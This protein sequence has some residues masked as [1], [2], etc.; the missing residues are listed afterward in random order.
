MH[1]APPPVTRATGPPAQESLIQVHGHTNGLKASQVKA[2]E[3]LLRRR[4]SAD[5]LVTNELARELTALSSEIRRQVGVL[6]DRAGAV[7]HA[8]VGSPSETELP[9][10]GRLRAGRGRLRGL[11][12][13]KTHLADEGLTRDDLTDLAL[14]RLD[15]VVSIAVRDDG[16]PGLAHAASLCAANPDGRTTAKL[17]PCHPADLDAPFSAFIRDLENELARTTATHDVGDGERAILVSVTAGRDRATLEMHVAELRELARAAGVTVVD[18]ITQ[19]RPAVDPRTVLGAGKLS[20]LAIRCFQSDVDLVIF[21]QDMTPAQA[22]NLAERMELRVIDRTQLILDIFAQRASTGDG[23]LQVELAQLRYRMPRLSQR[24]DLSLSRLAAGIGGRGPGETKL[25]SDRRR[26]RD[27][28]TRLE[29]ETARLADQREGRRRKRGRRSVPVL[30]IVGYTN[31]GKSTLLRALTQ[32]DVHVED[33]MFAT[34]DPVSRRLRFPREREVI[35]TDTVGFIR[36]LPADLAAAFHA[37]LEELRDANL[38]LHVVD[39]AS[40]DIDRR[41]QAVRQVLGELGFD[42]KPEL[43][44]FNQIDRMPADQVDGLARRYGAVA[45]SALQS[46]GLV[47]LLERAEAMLWDDEGGIGVAARMSEPRVAQAGR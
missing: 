4:L 24:A 23:K 30:S 5:R 10:W 36:D 44:V 28:I 2:L 33:K 7:Q 18:V 29:R 31:A 22:R 11:R 45:V 19:S 37:T 1:P 14:L 40:P 38:L 9:D 20:D 34:L 39:A 13:I 8:M 26:V 35:I 46:R 27:R 15:A 6:V 25:E 3:R 16:L 43:L 42:E 32:S 12:L 21:D 17:A 41:I 47:E